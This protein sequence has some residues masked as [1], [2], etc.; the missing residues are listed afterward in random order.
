MIVSSCNNS[1]QPPAAA[2]TS[3][4]TYQQGT[5]GYDQQF[6]QNHDSI[7]V[8]QEGETRVIISP[9]YQ[10]KVFTSTTSGENGPSFGWIHYKAFD[11]PIDPHMNAYGGENRLW[12]GPEG[13][14]FSLFFQPGAKMEFTN[15]K[16]PAAFDTE[17]WE[18]T[19]KD[20]GAV[21]L[22]K[23][24]QLTNYAGTHLKLSITRTIQILK[25][26]EIDADLD[27][28]PDS[29]VQAV[30][31][32][33]TNILSNTGDNS[34]TEQ[35]GMPCIW[36]LDMFNPS[37]NTTIIIPYDNADGS[38]PATTDYFGEIPGDRI[39]FG[40]GTL[41]FKADG[42]SRGKLGIH[43]KRAKP[44]AG[45]Y[46]AVHQTLTITQ[47]D[48]EPQGQY[49]NQEWN[50]TKPPFSGDA[51]NAYNDGPLADGKQM[52]PFYEIESVGSAQP[53]APGATQTHKHNVYHFTG[54]EAGLDKICQKVLGVSLST[55]KTS[56][57]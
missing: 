50:T 28:Q 9:K 1:Q 16:T 7:I 40:N 21:S 2:A 46:D 29:S 19:S 34:W 57:Q 5:F 48:V 24:M 38:K 31:Y 11:G 45:S 14:K 25:R 56:F 15:W 10:G 8:L 35:T 49:L 55:I 36:M 18:V 33:T 12:L 23:D 42:K 13:G 4:P 3:E 43:P 22:K 17:T 53:L 47:F 37:P 39:K 44:F 54:S 20:A 32:Q 30:G 51:V 26:S 27:I 6:L 41:F 52:G